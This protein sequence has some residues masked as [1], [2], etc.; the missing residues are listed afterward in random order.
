[1]RLG[2]HFPIR[3]GL[4][5]PLGRRSE[6]VTVISFCVRLLF[7]AVVFLVLYQSRRR[8][9]QVASVFAA[10]RMCPHCGRI[11]ARSA[12]ACLECGGVLLT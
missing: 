10:Q 1:M 7:A 9:L 11:T 3:A 4:T 2:V 6:V 8:P 12:A 5:G